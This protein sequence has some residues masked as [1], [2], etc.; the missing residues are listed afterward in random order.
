M[1][2]LDAKKTA[3]KK[4]GGGGPGGGRGGRGG[5]RGGHSGGH[6]GGVQLERNTWI[7]LVD[8]LRRGELLPVV[9]FTFS[10]ARCDANA[11]SLTSMNLTSEREKN[12]IRHFFDR[13]A[14]R[15]TKA[16]QKLPQ[17]RTR[18][19]VS[20]LGVESACYSTCDCVVCFRGKLCD[21][22]AGLIAVSRGHHQ[23]TQMS[24]LLSRG[25]G[26]HHSGVLPIL[27]EVIELLFQRGLVKVSGGTCLLTQAETREN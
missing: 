5:G 22:A 19:E 9:A 27:K 8:H 13:C 7:G 4:G 17:V 14:Q 15:L 12:E 1:K 11:A 6:G 10:R 20:F 24:D 3:M 21:A 26:V 16:D 25:V 18:A 2:A 23:V